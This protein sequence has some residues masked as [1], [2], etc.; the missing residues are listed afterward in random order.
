MAQ[1]KVSNRYA[2]ALLNLAI[3]QKSL[4]AC[5]NDMALLNKSCIE[6]KD[7]SLMLKSP[8]VNTDKKISILNQIFKNKFSKVSMAFVAIIT[9][10]KRESLLA[11]ISSSFISLYKAHNNVTTASVVTAQP[12]DAD[13][14]KELIKFIKSG[15]KNEVELEEIVD[16]KI[17]GGAIIRMGDKQIDTSVIRTIKDLKKTYNKNLYIKDF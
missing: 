4:D 12:I 13:L 16:E 8:I 2:K 15:D 3:E 9:N 1:S 14:K 6:N 11:D 17:I 5:F 10:K 7:L